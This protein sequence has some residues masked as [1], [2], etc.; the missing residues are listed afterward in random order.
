MP[1]YTYHCEK[2]GHEFEKYQT[3]SEEPLIVCPKCHKE[4]L[5]KVYKPALVVFKGS[6]YYVTDHKSAKSS[7]NNIKKESDSD[8]GQGASKDKADK[9]EKPKK[10]KDKEAS[11]IKS[12]K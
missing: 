11:K 5:R 2:C 8:N 10:P 1:S 4:A 9:A 12:E 7:L 6:G 3:F